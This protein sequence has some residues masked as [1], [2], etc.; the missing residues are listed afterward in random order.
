MISTTYDDE[1]LVA[2]A[3]V[4]YGPHC[5]SS[6]EAPGLTTSVEGVC[7][8]LHAFSLCRLPAHRSKSPDGRGLQ[9]SRIDI[10]YLVHPLQ[11]VGGD[12]LQSHSRAIIR[13]PSSSFPPEAA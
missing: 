9:C 3:M 5:S 1:H 11:L 6:L 4:E 13:A 10:S 12:R 2:K 7:R 8:T